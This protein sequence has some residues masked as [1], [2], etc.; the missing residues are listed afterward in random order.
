M[1][2]THTELKLNQGLPSDQG[3]AIISVFSMCFSFVM[4]V[5]SS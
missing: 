3:A 1:L 5:L 2:Q 4:L